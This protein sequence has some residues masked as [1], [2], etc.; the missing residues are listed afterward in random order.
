SPLV[1]YGDTSQDASEFNDIPSIPTQYA[2]HFQVIPGHNQDTLDA[3]ASL[4]GVAMYGGPHNDVIKGSQGD[5][6]LAGGSGNDTIHGNGGNDLIYGDSGFNAVFYGE[7]G[8]P[9]AFAGDPGL[10]V[11]VGRN[12]RDV[13]VPTFNTAVGASPLTS[14]PN[15][16]PQDGDD[17]VAG[18]DVITGDAGN[19]IVFGDHGIITQTTLQAGELPG[20]LRLVSP[21]PVKRAET[22]QDA[23]G[24]SDTIDGGTGNDFLFGGYGGDTITDAIGENVIFGDFGYINLTPANPNSPID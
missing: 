15:G 10:T 20:T 24:V 23:N 7:P 6:S 16:S 12:T 8:F 1:I 9:A 14:K 13:A 4:T 17:L 3:S 22:T 11:N 19:D 18:H 5:D 21:G 2:R